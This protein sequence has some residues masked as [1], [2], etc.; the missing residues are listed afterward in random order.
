[1]AAAIPTVQTDARTQ[2][3]RVLTHIDR[4]LQELGYT[5]PDIT[6]FQN[7]IADSRSIGQLLSRLAS[8]APDKVA[9]TFE[10]RTTTRA[11]LR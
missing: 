11:S 4:C 1:M 6:G 10:G 3:Q 2:K 9:I 8:E 5:R 7:M